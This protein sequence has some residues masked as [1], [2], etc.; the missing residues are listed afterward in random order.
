MFEW[1]WGSSAWQL[2]G[3]VSRR[4]VISLPT[5]T[6]LRPPNLWVQQGC[7]FSVIQWGWESPEWMGA[8]NLLDRVEMEM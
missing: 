1:L 8:G 3:P 6:S 7:T 5:Q 4:G 2:P